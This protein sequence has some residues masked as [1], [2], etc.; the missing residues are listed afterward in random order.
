MKTVIGVRDISV[1]CKDEAWYVYVSPLTL[2]E[3]DKE[4]ARAF[5][6]TG[7]F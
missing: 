7:R 4:A 3:S 2:T 5:C 1:P 6:G